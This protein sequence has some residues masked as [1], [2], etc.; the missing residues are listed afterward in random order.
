M[1]DCLKVEAMFSVYFTGKSS[2]STF[3]AG[4]KQKQISDTALQKGFQE[5]IRNIRAVLIDDILAEYKLLHFPSSGTLD[6]VSSRP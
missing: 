6:H 2:H 4:C 3:P 5:T 1:S